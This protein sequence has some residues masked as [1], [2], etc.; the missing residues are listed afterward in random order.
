MTLDLASFRKACSPNETLI[1]ENAEEP[2]YIDLSSI[3]GG[4][5]IEEFKQAITR[6]SDEP[7]CQLLAAPVG[8][9]KSQELQRLKAELEEEGWHVVYCQATQD[10]D[11]ADIDI[12]DVLLMVTRQVSASLEDLGIQLSSRYFAILFREIN[13]ILQFPVQ[14]SSQ[15][16]LS[17]E[18]GKLTANM[19]E[20]PQLRLQLRLY[21]ES[22]TEGVLNAINT[23]LLQIATEELKR[24]GKKG[25]VAIINELERVNNRRLPLGRL[26]PEYLF[27]EQGTLL[28]RL[29]CH[30]V[31]NI[32]LAL[33]YSSEYEVLKTG[34][35]N[36]V[37]PKVLPMIPVRRRDGSDYQEGMAL[38]RQVVLVRAFPDLQ[39]EQ[40]LGLIPE[41]FDS[42]E[43]LD[44]L[45]RISGGYVRHLLAL[46][47]KCFW[48]EEPPFSHNSV[49]TLIAEYRNSLVSAIDEHEWEL[50]FQVQQSKQV[51]THEE[52]RLLRRGMFIYEYHDS[53]GPWFDLN[54]VL[55][56]AEK[57]TSLT[58]AVFHSIENRYK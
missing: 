6:S 20:N 35:G 58:T 41:I 44:R 19:K 34:L 5:L 16:K 55:T 50:L 28:S 46:L 37:A 36:G 38:L 1:G 39:P 14:V 52:Y 48:E 9:W 26:Q 13:L 18:I 33:L 15:G 21:L 40:R 51:G 25:L 45:C 11:L 12:L 56:E 53:L 22:R 3:R 31:Y 10:L 49:E 29:N 2:Y 8:S 43:T 27:I 23:E 32:P 17:E 57:V 4:T 30:V 42:P 54:P 7:T 47:Y 24:L